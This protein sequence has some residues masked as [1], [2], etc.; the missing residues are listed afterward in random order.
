[1]SW[2]LGIKTITQHE[3]IVGQD[4]EHI[5]SASIKLMGKKGLLNFPEEIRLG[6]G[7]REEEFGG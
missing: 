2:G 4:E 7:D 1:M 3:V 6:G 5:G